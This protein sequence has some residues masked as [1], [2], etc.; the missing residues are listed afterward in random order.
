MKSLQNIL[1]LSCWLSI[2]AFWKRGYVIGF[3]DLIHHFLTAKSVLG[4]RRCPKSGPSRSPNDLFLHQVGESSWYCHKITRQHCNSTAII[5]Q[6]CSSL[7]AWACPSLCVV[8]PVLKSVRLFWEDRYSTY[9]D[10]PISWPCGMVVRWCEIEVMVCEIAVSEICRNSRLRWVE[11]RCKMGM[12]CSE[13]TV[14]I[15]HLLQ[16]P[17]PLR[18]L[19]NFSGMSL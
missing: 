5:V 11:I 3:S 13:R 12:K 16:A 17:A 15:V 10:Y 14:G 1:L 6:I 2:E 7:A 18:Q 9:L 4:F 8:I 19:I